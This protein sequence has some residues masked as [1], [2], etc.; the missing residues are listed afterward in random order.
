MVMSEKKSFFLALKFFV[1]DI[2]SAFSDLFKALPFVASRGRKFDEIISKINRLGERLER[3]EEKLGGAIQQKIDKI[4]IEDSEWVYKASELFPNFNPNPEVMDWEQRWDSE[5]IKEEEWKWMKKRVDYLKGEDRLNRIEE[6]ESI[7]ESQESLVERKQGELETHK[8]NLKT[9][10]EHLINLEEDKNICMKDIAEFR[11]KN[12]NPYKKVRRQI[13]DL[14]NQ[15]DIISSEIIS[16]EVE[17]KV[18]KEGLV[19]LREELLLLEKEAN[20]APVD[21]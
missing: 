15:I 6:I 8:N 12:R 20:P 13:L 9:Y 3:I 21:S 14:K 10:E 4:R 18:K 16:T 11:G 19:T 2:G 17:I 1:S 7:I 5:K